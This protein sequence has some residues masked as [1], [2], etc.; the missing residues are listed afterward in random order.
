MLGKTANGLFWMY[1][2]LER[3]ENTARLIVTGQRIALTRLRSG[4]S[5]WA[6]LLLTAGTLDA[7]SA[8]HGELQQDL[9]IE[10]LLRDKANPASVRSCIAAARSNA[11]LV[12]TA[13]TGEVWEAVNAAYMQSDALLK[14]KVT[15]RDLPLVLAKI[16]QHAAQVRGTTLGTLLRNE[17][18]D[19]TRLGTFVERADATARILDVKYYVLLP[20]VQ[21]VGSSLD[22]V[23]WETILR[24]VSGDGGFRMAYGGTGGPKEIVHFLVLDSRMPRSLSFC[25]RKMCENLNYLFSGQSGSLPSKEKADALDTAIRSRT[26]DD[27]FDTGLHEFLQDVLA[28]LGDITKQIETDFRFNE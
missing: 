18:Y 11:R 22:N 9:A 21:S 26:V 6:S 20:S 1:R 12:R 19:F 15:E 3:A 23:Q 25:A 27:I 2:Y 4:A 13:L 10:W 7:Y 5:E 14:H 16:R 24:S 17:I 8:E 28:R